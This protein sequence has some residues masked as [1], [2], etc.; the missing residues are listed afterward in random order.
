LGVIFC[1][2]P[3]SRVVVSWF[4]IS[5]GCPSVCLLL[6]ALAPLESGWLLLLL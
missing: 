5:F 2:F 3:S 6:A 1:S 4:L